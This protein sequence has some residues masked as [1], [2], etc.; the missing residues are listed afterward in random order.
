MCLLSFTT[1]RW[2]HCFLTHFIPRELVSTRVQSTAAQAR[3]DILPWVSSLANLGAPLPMASPSTSL[4]FLPCRLCSS[5][6]KRAFAQ[7][8]LKAPVTGHSPACQPFST[9]QHLSEVDKSFFSRGIFLPANLLDLIKTVQ[10]CSYVT[11]HQILCSLSY[12]VLFQA[13]SCCVLCSTEAI[14]KA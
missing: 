5:P 12:L 9:A 10:I 14:Y 1:Q 4:G 11:A 7:V 3:E 2:K 6:E 8:S 13:S